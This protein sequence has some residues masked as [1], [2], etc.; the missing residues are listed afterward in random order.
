MDK[1]QLCSEPFDEK[2]L[3]EAD[4]TGYCPYCNYKFDEVFNENP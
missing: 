1:C 3:K 4:E 2:D